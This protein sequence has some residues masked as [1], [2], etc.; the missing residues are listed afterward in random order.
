MDAAIL[1]GIA[2]IVFRRRTPFA[3]R[4]LWLPRRSDLAVFGALARPLRAARSS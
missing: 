2:A 3:W 4:A 1:F